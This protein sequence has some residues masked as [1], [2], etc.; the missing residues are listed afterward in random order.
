MKTKPLLIAL[1]AIAVLICLFFIVKAKYFTK[2]GQG[3]ITQFL[4]DFNTELQSGHTDTLLTYFESNKYKKID[5]LVKVLSGKTGL[6]G[7]TAALFKITL[8][9][10]NNKILSATSDNTI[11]EVP[12]SFFADSIAEKISSIIFTIH[13]TGDHQFKI[14]AV[15]MDKFLKDYGAYASLVRSKTTPAADVYSAITLASFKVA[16]QLKSSY[17]SVLWFDHVGDKTYYYVIRGKLNDQ[18]Y[19]GDDE[20]AADY[21]PTY[22]MGLVNPDMKEIIPVEFDLVHNVNGTIPGLI[23]VEKDGK[24]GFYNLKGV[25]VLP[26]SYDQIFPLVNDDNLA[27]LRV[28]S[29]YFYLKS[30]TTLSPKIPDLK[31]ADMLPKIK[32]YGSTYTLSDK[33]EQDIMEYNDRETFTSIIVAPSYLVDMRLLTRFLTFQNPLRH[34]SADEEGDG[35]GS[36]T[37]KI[38]FDGEKQEDGNWFKTAFYSLYDDYLGG[39]SGLYE[40]KKVLI[41]DKKQNRMFSFGVSS[42]DNEGEGGGGLSGLCNENSFHAINDTLFEFRTT[43]EFDQELLNNKHTLAEG[44]CY[45]YLHIQNGKLVAL[46]NTRIFGCTKY[47]KLDDSYLQGCYVINIMPPGN[48][49]SIPYNSGKNISIDRATPEILQYMKNEIY[50]SYGYRFKSADWNDRFSYRF[51]SDTT[52]AVNVDDSLTVIDKYNINFLNQKLKNQ[53]SK[54]LA[55]R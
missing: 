49:N 18:F 40:E 24:K 30:D 13:K 8:D 33:T 16:A 52:K 20:R 43:S 19:W 4:T 54:T 51:G 38:E 7:K 17:D 15:K 46:P 6:N 55:A 31:I 41:V 36:L 22:K 50:A 28:G 44:P 34:P 29:D 37:L 25:L 45:Y 48:P 3:E 5:L 23:E 9:P 12:V 35:D 53:D 1:A 14:T 42:Y 32:T 39:R 11:V 26:A 2:P 21:A 47:I 27:L 10:K